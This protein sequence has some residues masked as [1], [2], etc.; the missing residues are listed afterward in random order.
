MA[1]VNGMKKIFSQLDISLN[2]GSAIIYV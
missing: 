2:N 1:I